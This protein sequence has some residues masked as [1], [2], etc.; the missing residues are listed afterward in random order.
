[1][2]LLFA[3]IFFLLLVAAREWKRGAVPG[4]GVRLGSVIPLLLMLLIE[5]W[6]SLALYNPIF[7]FMAYSTT[8]PVFLDA[9]FSAFAGVGLLLVCLVVG[10]LSVPTARKTWRRAR[11][12]RIPIALL[13]ISAIVGVTYAVIGLLSWSL[14]TTPKL[15]WPTLSPL[16]IWVLV[17]QAVLAFAEEVYYRGLVLSEVERLAPR[18]GARKPMVS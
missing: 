5:K 16:L 15:V 2:S 18:L 6:T 10:R 1:M 3:G 4:P 17:G 12:G 13:G 14:G 7:Y 8:P 9:Q 11:P